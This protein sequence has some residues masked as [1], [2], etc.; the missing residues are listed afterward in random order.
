MS[1]REK[2]VSSYCPSST[3]HACTITSAVYETIWQR[4]VATEAFYYAGHGKNHFQTY[5]VDIG[6]VS[7]STDSER[8]CWDNSDLTDD[9]TVF[10]ST[11]GGSAFSFTHDSSKNYAAYATP[12]NVLTYSS[13]LTVDTT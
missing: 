5:P 8:Q 2:M 4:G 12:E 6:F 7:I 10:Q 13:P 3:T 11:Y 1:Y 9:P